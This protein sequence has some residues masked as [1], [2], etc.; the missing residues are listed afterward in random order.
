MGNPTADAL[1]AFLTPIY[2]EEERQIRSA[3]QGRWRSR[4]FGRRD[5]YAIVI[6]NAGSPVLLGAFEGPHS[7]ADA[8]HACRHDPGRGLREVAAKRSRLALMV[9]AHQL[10]DQ[11]AAG[12]RGDLAMTTGRAVMATL[13]VRHDATVYCDRPGYRPEWNLQSGVPAAGEA[14]YSTHRSWS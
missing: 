13:A 8:L 3:S 12:G 10:K 4:G 7:S 5:S 9:E 14:A 2:D 11:I 6:D 1:T